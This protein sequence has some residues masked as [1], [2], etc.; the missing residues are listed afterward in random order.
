VLDE[1][2]CRECGCEILSS[3]DI[4]FIDIEIEVRSIFPMS[5]EKECFR[6]PF[7]VCKNCLEETEQQWE[8]FKLTLE[9]EYECSFMRFCRQFDS[10]EYFRQVT[11]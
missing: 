4:G 3:M 5:K 10:D 11:A 2:Y 1:Y 9:Y 6:K 8:N 7:I